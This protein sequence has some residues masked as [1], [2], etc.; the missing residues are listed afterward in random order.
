MHYRVLYFLCMKPLDP[1]LLAKKLFDAVIEDQ[2][3]QVVEIST[4]WMES[5]SWSIHLEEEEAEE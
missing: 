4:P 3:C 5:C 1:V 2:P